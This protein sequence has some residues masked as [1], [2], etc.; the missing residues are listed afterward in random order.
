MSIATPT[1]AINDG[2]LDMDGAGDEFLRRWKDEDADKPSDEQGE[3]E[4]LE[5]DTET[6]E[7]PDDSD[8]SPE[9]EEGDEETDETEESDDQDESD[10]DEKPKKALDD[11][12]VVKVKVDGEELDV[13]VKD[14]KRL[15]GQEKALTRKSQEVAQERKRVEDNGARYVA[16]LSTL[17]E[18]A[19]ERFKPY[20]EIDWLVAAQQ[21]S[22]DELTALRTEA[23][24]ASEDLQFL[25]TELDGVMRKADHERQQSLRKQAAA[26]IEYLKDEKTGIKGWSDKVYDDIRTYAVGKGLDAGVVNELTDPIAIKIMHQSMLYEKGQ[27]AL[28]QTKKVDKTPK[29]IIKGGSQTQT[30]QMRGK[31]QNNA[32]QKLQ[33]TGDMEDAADAFL[34]RFK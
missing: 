22:P 12:A 6:E 30:A 32:F 28:T 8:E 21:L 4:D 16:G 17:L 26:A 3:T 1:G 23:R 5:T 10:E 15:Y 13:P 18:K 7:T 27:K 34:E 29:K 20:A 33:R 25:G 19:R 11:D 31:T 14:L 24:K 9:D 2:T